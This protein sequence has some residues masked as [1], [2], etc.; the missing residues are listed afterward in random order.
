L[1][2][3]VSRVESLNE[4][5]GKVNRLIFSDNF[6]LPG[7]LWI[8]RGVSNEEYR[9]E[10]SLKWARLNQRGKQTAS[11]PYSKEKERLFRISRGDPGLCHYI[12]R[13]PA[14]PDTNM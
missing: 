3:T 10:V 8:F 9:L 5:L 2:S 13:F 12:W 14:W 4:Y 6:E 1:D 11:L 7:P